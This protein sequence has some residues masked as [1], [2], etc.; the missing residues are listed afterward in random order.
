MKFQI[1]AL[2]FFCMP[3]AWAMELKEVS[4]SALAC[5]IDTSRQKYE[6]VRNEEIEKA[7]R[8]CELRLGRATVKYAGYLQKLEEAIHSQK[9]LNKI[10][11]M[12]RMSKVGYCTVYE[13]LLYRTARK[14][15]LVGILKMMLDHGADANFPYR[16]RPTTPLIE[17]VNA[18]AVENVRVLLAA[19]AL[20]IIAYPRAVDSKKMEEIL[21]LLVEHGAPP[22]QVYRDPRYRE[23]IRIPPF[24]NN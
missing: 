6:A 8:G 18:E 2:S 21:K 12:R 5:I 24:I 15:K 13:P 16:E 23:Y 11:V 14:T 7:K 3:V 22:A 9:N 20:P 17:A 19:R 4:S 1:I 10:I